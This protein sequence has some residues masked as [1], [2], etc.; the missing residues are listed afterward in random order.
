MRGFNLREGGRPSGTADLQKA[1]I[2]SLGGSGEFPS[3]P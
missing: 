3:H 2:G 1:V